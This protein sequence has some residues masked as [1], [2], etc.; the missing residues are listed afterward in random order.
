M[1]GITESDQ[2]LITKLQNMVD[3]LNYERRKLYTTRP[4]C[5]CNGRHLCALHAAVYNHLT[6]AAEDLARA[7]GQ[8]QAEG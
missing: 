6:E 3:I 7:I 1:S 8:A 2:A 4:G 5:A